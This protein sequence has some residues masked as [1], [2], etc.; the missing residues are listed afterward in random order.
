MSIA[1]SLT[2]A[3]ALATRDDLIAEVRAEL[4]RADLTDGEIKSFIRRFEARANRLLRTP[5]MESIGSLSTSTSAALLPTDFLE[6]RRVVGPDG[7]ALDYVSPSNFIDYRDRT[8]VY[9][10]ADGSIHIS[11]APT[12]ATTYSLLYWAKVPALTINQATNWL[13]DRH[14][15]AYFYGTLVNAETRIANDDRAVLWKAALDECFAEIEA[16]ARRN[17]TGMTPRMRAGVHQTRGARA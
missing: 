10:L 9:T 1:V 12:T 6:M 4:N 2:E 11:P 14:P 13:L 7:Y 3:P 8:P 5:E 16:E 17:S 15:D